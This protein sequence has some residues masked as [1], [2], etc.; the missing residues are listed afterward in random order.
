MIV[1]GSVNLVHDLAEL[2]F[3][4][5]FIAERITIGQVEIIPCMTIRAIIAVFSRL[6][7]GGINTVDRIIAGMQ[8]TNSKVLLAGGIQGLS[9]IHGFGIP[10]RAA[11][12]SFVVFT[13]LSSHT[14]FV[15]KAVF[16]PANIVIHQRV[17]GSPV[18]ELSPG[19]VP[20]ELAGLR[21]ERKGVNVNIVKLRIITRHPA[22]EGIAGNPP[23]KTAVFGVN[24]HLAHF[25]G[26]PCTVVAE[27]AAVNDDILLIE[28]HGLAAERDVSFPRPG[29]GK[30]PVDFKAIIVV[31]DLVIGG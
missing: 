8:V 13:K 23:G 19:R 18:M 11:G 10:E 28:L 2:Q 9:A 12:S 3:A 29:S 16:Q 24:S 31:I 25:A 15:I 20:A 30:E 26:N 5:P 14:K 17:F 7:K 27:K 6:I 21:A 22:A 1:V 4:N